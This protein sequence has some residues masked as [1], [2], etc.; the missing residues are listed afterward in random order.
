MLLKYTLKMVKMA[1]F[2]LYTCFTTMKNFI[3]KKKTT[4]YVK[5]ALGEISAA[6]YKLVTLCSLSLG[7]Q[8][9]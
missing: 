4:L 3:K 8:T 7:S 5:V 2:I 1:N 6:S 9:L